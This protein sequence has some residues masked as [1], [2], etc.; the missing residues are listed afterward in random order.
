MKTNNCFY[1]KITLMI[2][3]Q[4]SKEKKKIQM[5]SIGHERGDTTIDL[6]EI[7]RIIR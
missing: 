2:L 6:T 7:K 1:E 5:T 3:L 4:T